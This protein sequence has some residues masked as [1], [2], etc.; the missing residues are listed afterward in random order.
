MRN[1][2]DCKLSLVT[3][4]LN[5]VDVCFVRKVIPE[6]DTFCCE[7]ECSIVDKKPKISV[8]P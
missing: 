3:V 2:S 6:G 8:K 5:V 1:D 7:N 4:Q